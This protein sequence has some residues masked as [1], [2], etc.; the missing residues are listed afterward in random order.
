MTTTR[1][2][3][4]LV[5]TLTILVMY[6]IFI[7]VL[8]KLE[9]IKDIR[10]WANLVIGIVGSVGTYQLLAKGLL[11]LF[12][13]S[14]LLR[15]MVLGPEFLEGTWIGSYKDPAGE[16]RF[17]IEYFE[18]GLEQVLVR[19]Q[20]FTENGEPYGQWLSRAVTVDPEK[21]TIV[22][23]Y[24]CD[25]HSRNFSFQGIALF[26]FERDNPRKAPL[27]LNGY[28]ADLIDGVRS[29]N[30]QHKISDGKVDMLEALRT[31]KER[32]KS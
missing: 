18:Q 25:V 12:N 20:A 23:T 7:F 31:A 28:S 14:R 27:V 4:L 11:W 9:P 8:P 6:Q 24:D 30:R 2:F 29:S 10:P 21:G 15:K 16:M 13:W 5:S 19:G 3:H 26:Q 22:Y 32:F 1:R 17:T